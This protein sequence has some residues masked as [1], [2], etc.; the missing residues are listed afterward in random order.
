MVRAALGSDWDCA[1]ANDIDPMKG[2]VYADNWGVEALV[3]GDI[4]H[5]DPAHLRQ[6]IDLYWASS[7]CQDFSLAGSGSGLS[8]ARSGVFL[9]WVAQ[10]ARAAA[11]GHAPRL[12]AFENVVGLVARHGGRDFAEVLRRLAALGYHVGALEIDARDFVPQSRPRLFVVCV[13]KDVDI[14]GLHD[15]APTGP[16]HTAKL[17]RVLDAVPRSLRRDWKWWSHAAPD[18]VRPTLA[19][20]LDAAPDTDWF[21]RARVASLVSLMSKPSLDRLHRAMA[22]PGLS[23]GTLYRRGRPDADGIVRQRAE[24]RFDGIA[25]CL[26]TPAGGSSRQTLVLVHSKDVRARLLSTRECA[27]LMGLS[28]GFRMPPNYNAA[29]RVAGDGVVVPVVEW[30]DRALFR[31]LLARSLIQRVA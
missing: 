7:P 13:R 9:T 15:A 20:L 30:L 11:D 8:G 5:L 31:P 22:D 27:R 3:V 2:R 12:I 24:L 19:S 21:D 10:I 4:A 23:V 17:R 14:A 29:Y 16:Y 28:D 6:P 1:L 25:G 26:R 18:A